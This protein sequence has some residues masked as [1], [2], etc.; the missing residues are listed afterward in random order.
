MDKKVFIFYC[1]IFYIFLSPF[2]WGALSSPQVQTPFISEVSIE[3]IGAPSSEEH[4]DLIPIKA[5]EPFSIKRISDSIKQLYKT[6]LFSDIQVLKEGDTRV[7]LIFIMT[8]TLHVRKINFLTKN[9]LP[10]KKIKK[11]LYVLQEGGPFLESKLTSAVEEIKMLLNEEGYFDPQ[12]TVLTDKDPLNALVDVYFR[13]DS[14]RRFVIHEIIFDG[15][16]IISEEQLKKEMKSKEGK[17]FIQSDLEKDVEKLKE[18]YSSLDYRRA[19]IK[20]TDKIFNQDDSTV[21]LLLHVE[22]HEKIDI[23]VKGAKVPLEIL[24][25]IWEARIFE[26]WGLS[27]GEAKIIAYMRKNGYLFSSVSSHIERG[28]NLIRVMYKV[29]PGRKHKIGDITFQGIRY[30]SPSQIRDELEIRKNI[31]FFS[32]IDG[33]RI[34]ELP[35]EIE[36]LYKT[37]GF[38]NPRV[39]LNF[40]K[41]GRGIK[42]IF[43]IEEG[44]QE[45]IKDISFEGDSFF[46]EEKLMG[47][48][49]SAQEGPFYY[50][51]VQKDVEKLETFYLNHGF[52]GTEVETR[53]NKV[54]E[55]IFSICFQIKEGK[56]VKIKKIVITG[57]V[58]TKKS[59]IL[60]ELLIK[61]DDYARYD[62]IRETKRRLERLGVFTEVKIEEI[63]LSQDQESLLISLREGERNYSSLGIGIE[64]KNEPRSFEVWN[65]VIRPRG[66]AEFIRSN[67][68]GSAAQLSV[69]GQISLKEKRGV[70]S[71]EQPYFFGIPMPTYINVWLEKEERK[72][73]SFDRRGISLTSI[74][75][76]S[77][78]GD[79]VLLSTLRLAR[80]T[81]F[82]LQVSESEVDR[83]HFPFSAS[84]I[85]GSFIWDKRDDP[86][87]P[88][89]GYFFSSAVEWA[90]PL[91]K[92]ESNFLKTFVKY[93][94]YYSLF[95]VF[96]IST[97][98]RL[99]LG[100]GRM[101]IHER[102]FAGGSNSFRGAEFDEL[103][104]KDPDSLKP[105]GGKA[106]FLW[107]L[108]ITW[109]MVYV[110][111]NL[112]GAAFY[113]TG[114]VFAKRSN[115]S[116]ADFQHA[117]GIALR[118]R[119]PLGPVRFELGWNLS[120]PERER[121]ILAFITIGNVF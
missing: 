32:N 92:V 79:M 18:I 61:E 68:F 31:P 39:D 69:V 70:M 16:K 25:P 109:P 22:P 87:N 38:S 117:I 15:D 62:L 101:P 54:G 5:G 83:Q 44:E 105:V 103:G 58:I 114:N 40:K 67:L 89:N 27:E 4:E 17:V 36:Y 55:N 41:A 99:G 28:N 50:P 14:V 59:V 78:T 56:R 75:S 65:N 6:R 73:Y 77:E 52:R 104:P 46:E 113:D 49:S 94:H 13:I 118:Y 7:K 96:T 74:K 11:G 119:T 42:P 34:F 100:R 91:F 88:E 102:F 23:I 30:F 19:E 53:I 121:K 106:M 9:R 26:E 81:L 47:Q 63:S 120:P 35:E 60:R 33:A 29:S 111:K 45:K 43:Y 85:S 72:S 97:T 66:T 48:I 86:F 8:R 84:S 24:L 95:P 93:Q 3:V 110:F 20:V 1:S 115:F 37:H 116:L 2:T 76:L 51:N 112:Y 82:N 64:T 108:E 90:Y 12:I 98:A 71:W 10:T 80:T 107:N 57:N 21:S